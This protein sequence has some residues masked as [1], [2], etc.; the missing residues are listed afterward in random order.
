MTPMTSHSPLLSAS[1]WLAWLSHRAVGSHLF[2]R[3]SFHNNRRASRM[4][5][6][7]NSHRHGCSRKSYPCSR[8]S[9]PRLD[10]IF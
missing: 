10:T 4:R 8:S 3:R 1:A 6:F 7:L 9:L 2:D 5:K